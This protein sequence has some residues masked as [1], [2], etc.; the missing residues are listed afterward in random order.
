MVVRPATPFPRGVELDDSV[1]PQAPEQAGVETVH[2]FGKSGVGG[3]K[4]EGVHTGKEE[5]ARVSSRLQP[6]RPPFFQESPFLTPAFPGP[7]FVGN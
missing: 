2:L 6:S 4:A 7:F 1:S 3:E 5:G